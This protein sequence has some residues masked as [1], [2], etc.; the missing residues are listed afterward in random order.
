[1]TDTDTLHFAVFILASLAAFLGILKLVLRQRPVQPGAFQLT[2]VS[3][4]VVVVGMLFAK[5]TVGSGFAWWVYYGVPAAATI[6]LP[7]IVFRMRRGELGLYVIVASLASPAIHL[8][9]SLFLGWKDYLPFWQ[10]PS[11]RE[12]LS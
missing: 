1:M 5:V 12:L 6:L 7:P 8:L 10:V 3:I 4:L 11:L 2:W 9:F